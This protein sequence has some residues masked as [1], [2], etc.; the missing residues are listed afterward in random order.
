MVIYA[1]AFPTSQEIF[2]TVITLALGGGLAKLYEVW[3]ARKRAGAEIDK[4]A[5]DAEKTRAE[6]ASVNVG[7]SERMLDRLE[8]KEV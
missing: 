7:I 6:A 2:S 5:A 4:T 1:M 8:R 3:N